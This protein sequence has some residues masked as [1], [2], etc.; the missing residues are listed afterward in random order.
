MEH[1]GHFT[2]LRITVKDPLERKSKQEV[3]GNLRH[4][5]NFQY[6]KR[7]ATANS[8]LMSASFRYVRYT[9]CYSVITLTTFIILNCKSVTVLGGRPASPA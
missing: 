3:V 1:V 8:K 7:F 4:L 2:K 5:H 6:F 9:G